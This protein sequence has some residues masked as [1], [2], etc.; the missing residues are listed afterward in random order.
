MLELARLL[1]PQRASYSAEF[2]SCHFAGEEL[3]LLGSADWVKEPTRPLDKAVAMLNMD[4]I[5]RIKDE[6]VY[7]GGVGPVQR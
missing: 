6:K 2:C 3:G 1:A 7:I 5:G 4:M